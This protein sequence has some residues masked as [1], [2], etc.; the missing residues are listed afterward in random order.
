MLQTALAG[1]L[2][3]CIQSPQDKETTSVVVFSVDIFGIRLVF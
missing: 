2:V 3:L 1:K